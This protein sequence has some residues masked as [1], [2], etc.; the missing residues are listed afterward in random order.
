MNTAKDNK[1]IDILK[2]IQLCII[3]KYI[4]GYRGTA[5]WGGVP[6]VCNKK[7]HRFSRLEFLIHLLLTD[8]MYRLDIMLFELHRNR[9]YF[10]KY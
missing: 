10:F 2:L 7:N 5:W 4:I 3:H 6:V 1:M 9:F 8:R